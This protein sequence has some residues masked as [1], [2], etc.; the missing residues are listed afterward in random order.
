V[1]N[2]LDFW[3]GTFCLVLFATIETILFAWVFGMD[4]AWK[5]MHHGSMMQIPSV[6]KFIIKYITPSILIIILGA[7]LYQEGIP[8]IMMKGVPAANVPYIAGTRIMLVM[9]FAG[10]AFAVKTAWRQKK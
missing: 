6:Y 2:E 4:K 1:L 3:A 10:F 9:I 7:W 5:E 8:T